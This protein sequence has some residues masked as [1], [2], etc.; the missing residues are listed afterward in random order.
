MYALHLELQPTAGLTFRRVPFASTQMLTYPFAPAPTLSGYLERLRRLRRGDDLPETAL[1]NPPTIAL[2]SAYRV[3]GAYPADEQY[4]IH[5]TARQGPRS[6]THSAFSRLYR[7]ERAQSENFQLYAW[8]YLLVDRLVGWVVH[9]ERAALEE[10]ADLQNVGCKL[11]KEGYAYVEEV[12]I[13]ALEPVDGGRPRVAV[14]AEVAGMAASTVYP[15]YRYHRNGEMIV[16]YEPL[17]LALV[18]GVL[19]VPGYRTESGAFLPQ[20]SIDEL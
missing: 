20:V 17:R 8:E 3:L 4:R 2:P 16:G 6:I 14:P 15:V 1:K 5:R 7:Q 13:E 10:L 11:G 9:P 12:R 18:D 19:R